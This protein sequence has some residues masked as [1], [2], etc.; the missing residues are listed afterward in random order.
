MSNVMEFNLAKDFSDNPFGRYRTDG[1]NSGEAFR[2]DFLKNLLDK[3][4]ENNETLHIYIDDVPIGISSSFLSESFGGLVTKK[5]FSSD[6]LLS[7]LLTIETEDKSYIT[8]INT[9]IR[10][11]SA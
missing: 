5:Y 3:C 8:E 11:A 9:Y 2:E 6:E 7:S 10:E 1:P 4:K